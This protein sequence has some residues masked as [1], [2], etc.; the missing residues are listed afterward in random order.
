MYELRLMER[1]NVPEKQNGHHM[2]VEQI[3]LP[4]A[5]PTQ[6]AE[7]A[8]SLLLAASLRELNL[9]LRA[10]LCWSKLLLS[11]ADP[12]SSIAMDLGI[13]VAEA[14]RMHEIIR[15]LDILTHDQEV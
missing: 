5:S 10:I 1:V 4:Q 12:G 9:P 13:I 2:Q 14:Q 3:M 15:G 7:E 8:L 6:G 11:E